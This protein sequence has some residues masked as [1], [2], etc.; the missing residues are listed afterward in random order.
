MFSTTETF[1]L[2]V[3]FYVTFILFLGLLNQYEQKNKFMTKICFHRHAN[4]TFFFW[5][6]V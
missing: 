2:Q 1:M 4:F 5:Q 6:I 3:L